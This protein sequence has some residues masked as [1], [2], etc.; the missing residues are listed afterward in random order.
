MT[1]SEEIQIHA[2]KEAVW[3]V[4][5]DIKNAQQTVSGIQSLE[6]L[7]KPVHGLVGL[8]WKESRKMF[9]KIAFE[10]MWITEAVENKCYK[11]EAVSHGSEYLSTVTIQEDN[12]HCILRM[13]FKTTPFSTGAKVMSGIMSG[14][15]KKL[16]KKLI[17]QDLQDLKSA[18]EAK[19]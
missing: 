15:L 6:I 8:K 2:N 9:G 13:T 16:M 5:S 12:E 18:I 11:V 7:E 1:L 19:G 3:A 4:I 10:T 17:K 14:L